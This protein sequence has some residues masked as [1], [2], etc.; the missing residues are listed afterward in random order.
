MKLDSVRSLKAEFTQTVRKQVKVRARS[1]VALEAAPLGA[2]PGPPQSISLGVAGGAGKGDYRLA[3]RVHSRKAL[4]SDLLQEI[5]SKA[6][7]EADVRYVGEVYKCAA[8]RAAPPWH[9]AATRP[10]LIGASVAHTGVTAGTLGGFVTPRAKGSS[11]VVM[12]LSNN[13][14]I[15]NE[16]DAKKG[17]AIVQPGPLDG[18]TKK[19][20][21][22]TLTDWVPLRVGAKNK[23]DCAVATLKQGI[24]FDAAQLKGI[25]TLAGVH[26]TG[27]ELLMEVAKVGR[28]T[29]V[30][31]GSVTAVE[32]DGLVVG[33]DIGDVEFDDQIEIEG[34][35]TRAFSDGGDSGSLIVEDGSCLAVAQLFAGSD[36]GGSNNR[37][38]TYATPIAAVLKALKVNLLF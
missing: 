18:G 38:L 34:A 20:T 14:V 31:R 2:H 13:H 19:N 6:K 22:A 1:L 8:R 26:P 10:L 27:P 28:T 24:G 16:N 23:V 7:G 11:G 3:V 33:Y 29:G 12:V 37:G 32:L 9:Q 36:Q 21:V 17:D 5:E 35:G 4:E 25:G 30:R 15:A